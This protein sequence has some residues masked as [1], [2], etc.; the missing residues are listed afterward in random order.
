M[1]AGLLGNIGLK[2]DEDD[3]YLG[4][5]GIRFHRHPGSHLS[6]KPGR[7]I[8][9]AELVETTRLYARGIAN[10]E[11]R[12][13]ET[14]GG[15]LLKKQLLEPHWEK[16][17]GQVV[18]LERATLYGLVV[19]SNRR[20]DFGT[21]DPVAAREIF[22]REA[23]VEGD[24]ETK[25][26]FAAANRKLI[27]QVEELEHKARRQDVLVDD[28]LIHAFYD[29]QVPK[30]RARRPDLRALVPRRGAAPAE[31]AAADARGA[32]APRGRRHHHAGVSADDPPRRHRLR[33]E[34]SARAGQPARRRHRHRA[35]VRAQRRQR[36]SL[37][38]AGARDAE[39]QAGRAGEDPA[40][41]AALAP[42]ALAGLRRRLHRPPSVRRRQ[43]ARRADRRRAGEERHRGPARR[44]QARAAGAAPADEPARRRRARPAARRIAPSGRA[45]GPA[46]R[47]GALGVPG[48]GGAA[49]AGAI[50]AA[51]ATPAAAPGRRASGA[52]SGG[53][54]GGAERPPPTS[55]APASVRPRRPQPPRP[56]PP[57][58]SASCRSS[59]R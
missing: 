38:M 2:S 21:V 9:A 41:A 40:A 16:K 27:A 52:R 3:S 18:A 29:Q 14:V 53:E 31:P 19:Y 7:W 25:L 26:P 47:P 54:R 42:R 58:P 30:R 48:A 24:W 50:A 39:G 46:R 13:L 35:A 20:V 8:V 5:R 4:A 34:L 36:G 43:P 51:P 55:R 10:I 28:E 45:Q 56:S 1:L 11:P 57:G 33:R 23:L 32:D 6:K 59:W 22:I 17:A 44:L 15:H 37:R 49:P 12:W